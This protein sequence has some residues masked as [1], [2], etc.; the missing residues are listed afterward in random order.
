MVKTGTKINDRTKTDKVY[1]P[2]LWVA[3]LSSVLLIRLKLLI[4]RYQTRGYINVRFYEPPPE[5]T[6][7]FYS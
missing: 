6:C 5:K 2:C 3:H 7:F 1:E 4:F